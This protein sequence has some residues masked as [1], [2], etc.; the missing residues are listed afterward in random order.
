MWLDQQEGRPRRA[1]GLTGKHK[2]EL[3]WVEIAPSRGHQ[4]TEHSPM[5][6]SRLADAILRVLRS[7]AEPLMAKDILRTVRTDLK[8]PE[9]SKSDVNSALYGE[10]EREGL[11]TRQPGYR[12]TCPAREKP[13]PLSDAAPAG[14]KAARATTKRTG[15]STS[16]SRVGVISHMPQQN[17]SDASSKGPTPAPVVTE[18][19]DEQ[20]KVIEAPPT[21]FMLVEAGPGTGKTAVACGRIAHLVCQYDLSPANILLISFTRTAVMEL[22]QR[23]TGYLGSRASGVCISTLDSEAWRLHQGFSDGDAQQFGG[24]DANIE[25]VR[26][27]FR[28]GK[29]EVLQYLE[30]FQHVV[31][32][33]AQDL[34]GIRAR[35]VLE[36]L[37]HLQND[38]GVTI[39]ADPAQAI[40]GF[41]IDDK[42][43]GEEGFLAML[44][45]SNVRDFEIH[46]LTT[47]HR[48]GSA[49]LGTIFKD[50]RRFLQSPGCGGYTALRQTLARQAPGTCPDPGMLRDRS[51]HLLLYRHRRDVA[52][53]SHELCGKGIPHR[54]RLSRVPVC[55]QAWVGWL[56][57]SVSGQALGRVDFDSVWEQRE[58]AKAFPSLDRDGCFDHLLRLARKPDKRIDLHQLRRILAR[59]RPPVEICTPECGLD[60]PILGTI[61]ASKGRE[62]PHVLLG[63]PSEDP[64]E[65]EDEE[66]RVLY[67]GATRARE[68]LHTFSAQKLTGSTIGE[69]GRLFW[70]QNN[71]KRLACVEFGLDGDVDL[72][73]PV[74]GDFLSHSEAEGLQVWLRDSAGRVEELTAE[75][76]PDWDW[77][78]YR[79][80]VSEVTP[81]QWI[82]QFND[83]V[84]RDLNTARRFFPGST[85]SPRYINK[86][87]LIAA[88]T[89][90][91]PVDNP[92][93][94]RLHEPHASSGFW[95]APIVRGYPLVKFGG[96]S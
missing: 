7:A 28:G 5:S 66:M 84:R 30:R 78:G 81:F 76:S 62:A 63:L 57:G 64:A 77:S 60:G 41:T 86:L 71:A 13:A 20:L 6:R 93:V 53:L 47:L 79:L 11:V 22:K 90:A 95:L 89:V 8:S 36:L 65:H 96:A 61:H 10:L 32:D 16:T 88:R 55:V 35:L 46:R 52:R 73:S 50:N 19:D 2:K 12:W 87:H 82:G 67:V 85:Y 68:S 58:M 26:D 75:N 54:L 25:Q 21:A 74:R 15:T 14:A 91:V 92:I 40:Y 42:A 51:D 56:L 9:L 38:C 69:G 34:M 37:T 17:A 33:E 18:W 1:E 59:S 27:L 45:D 4:A 80:R 44:A 43:V 72:F 23:I 31:I 29:V 49:Q 39:F 3:R 70:K 94:S 83:A 24:F 48:T